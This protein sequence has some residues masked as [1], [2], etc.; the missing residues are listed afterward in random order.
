MGRIGVFI[1]F[2]RRLDRYLKAVQMCFSGFDKLIAKEYDFNVIPQTDARNECLRLCGDCD[3][4]WCVDADE[5][6]RREDQL[7]IIRRMLEADAYVGLCRVIDYF[8]EDTIL[9]PQRRHVPVVIVNPNKTEFVDGRCVQL[10]RALLFD[11]VNVH[12]FGFCFPTEIQEWKCEINWDHGEYRKL[13]HSGRTKAEMPAE[14]RDL[15]EV[16][17][18]WPLIGPA[19][20]VPASEPS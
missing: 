12:H 14:I 20:T 2:S 18:A 3:L 17:G 11:D 10:T 8:S 19:A 7:K 6:I 5:L 9:H 13:L 16:A 1:P 4:V 15:L